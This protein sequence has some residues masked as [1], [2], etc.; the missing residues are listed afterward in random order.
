MLVVKWSDKVEGYGHNIDSPLCGGL[1]K[2]DEDSLVP[3]SGTD[4]D[5][6]MNCFNCSKENNDCIVPEDQHDEEFKNWR[7]PINNGQFRSQT[8]KEKRNTEE[9]CSKYAGS[10]KFN[11]IPREGNPE[12]PINYYNYQCRENM[13]RNGMWDIFSLPDLCNKEKK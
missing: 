13:I 1:Y 2:E 4:P 9:T 5:A 3:L 6:K 10:D 12:I 7:G 8:L 11:G